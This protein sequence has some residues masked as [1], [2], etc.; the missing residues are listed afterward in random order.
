LVKNEFQNNL[1]K[2]KKK[3]KFPK[4]IFLYK[5]VRIIK[6]LKKENRL[7]TNE[8]DKVFKS[9]K[10]TFSSF[11]L[12]TVLKKQ[13]QKKISVA[14][15]KKNEKTAVARVDMRRRIYKILQ[16]NFQLV[17]ENI[18]ASILVTKPIKEVSKENLQKELFKALE[19]AEIF[20]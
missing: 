13:G 10:K 16:E 4:G 17:S 1:L 9:G 20:S 2:K 19:K 12:I 6:M 7:T 18:N 15:S 8:F 5:N 14:I 11:F 3:K